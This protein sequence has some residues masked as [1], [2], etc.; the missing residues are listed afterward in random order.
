MENYL[1]KL[2]DKQLEA[3]TTI[4]GPLLVL[5]GAGSGKTTVLA[6]RV[7]YILQN[8]FARPWNILA[9]TFTNKAAREMRER[10]EK[11]IGSE[12]KSMWIG[13]FHSICIR[14]LRTC[15]DREGYEKD[16]VIYDSADSRT[17]MKECE[18]ELNIEEKTFPVRAV[19]SAVSNAK[20]NMIEPDA[21]TAVYG[22]DMRSRIIENL[23]SLYQKKLKRNS[24]L[25]FDDI[26]M[27]T[28]KIL[29]NNPDAAEKYQERFQYIHVD[30]YQDT[31]NTQYAMIGILAQGYG[32][33]CVVG[34]DDQSIYKFRGANVNNILDFESDYVGA[35][36]VSLEQNYRSTST[37]LNAA[38]KVIANNKKRM[39]KNL[40]TSKTD[41][42]KIY[43]YTASTDRDEARFI[44]EQI[45]RIY[46]ETGNY[47]SCAILY[48]TNAQSRAIE[49]ALMQNAIPYKVLA[50]LRF[51]DRKEIK[52]ITAYLRVIYNPDDDVSLKRIIN[53]PKR[54]IGNATID[55]LQQHASE[56]DTSCYRII[57]SIS[58]YPDLKAAAPRLTA[59]ADII[60]RL[61]KLAGELTID[62]FVKRVLLETGYQ[63]ML[64]SEGTIESQT[65][66]E[67]I[68]EFCNLVTQYYEDPETSGELGEFLESVTIV[69]DIDAYDETEDYVV[70]MTIHSAKGLE[71]PVVF[72]TG[73]EEGLFPSTRAFIDEEDMEE[74]RRLCYV[75]ITRA[76]ER[77]YVTKAMSR[78]KFGRIEQSD[79]SRFYDE[80]PSEYIEDMSPVRNRAKQSLEDFG[81][82]L[83]KEPVRRETQEPKDTPAMDMSHFAAGD[84][85]RHRRFGE[86]T[87]VSA[88][89]F[90]KDSIVLIDFDTAGTKRLMAAFA[91][92]ERI[93]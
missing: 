45:E 70:M 32:N 61:R 9:I 3:V 53:E 85:V 81:F 52:D 44:A 68:E 40:W 4:D 5:A 83:K 10:I 20:N 39:G 22:N 66:L 16:F 93:N 90:G 84:R 29:K 27:L 7:A 92:L 91:K 76:K 89:A 88:Q 17:L 86:G 80:I 49:E 8:T 73:M 63:G 25:D 26:I 75:A 38:N 48:R 77:L 6:N 79:A 30:E 31:N 41:G 58:A 34:D 46:K 74:E 14:I 82:S 19:L 54:K 37:I 47:R 87:V 72:L 65:R 21:Y 35:K 60:K 18:K 56:R 33:I 50:G 15:I 51:Y 78:F 59:F 69:S 2:N 71:F 42:E 28:V 64:E 67:N 62:K 43:A 1:K 55:R 36:K 13:T 12:A 23:Y 24:A 11:I 57:Q